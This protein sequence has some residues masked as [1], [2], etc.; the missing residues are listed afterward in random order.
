MAGENRSVREVE[1]LCPQL[2]EGLRFS[3]DEIGGR[4]VC[5]IEDTLASR[6]HRVGLAE[7]RFFRA[8]DGT[9]TVA[10]ILAQLARDGGGESF[11]EH[12]ALQMIRWLKDNH[13]LAVESVRDET[14]RREHAERLM[15]FAATWLNPL[16][17]K[18]PLARPDA[19]FARVEPA[20]RWAL[21]GFG[22]AVWLV[23][24]ITGAV[25]AGMD[26]P[27]FTS[28]FDGILSR[29]NWLWLFLVWAGLKVAHEFSHGIFCKHFGAAVRELGVIFVIFIPMGY[30]DATASVGLAS[31]WRRIMV[32]LAG[33]Y[34]EFFLAA[35]AAIVWARTGS[36]LLNTVAHN[37]VVTGTV[38][39]LLFNANPLMRFDGY[40][41]LS[42]LLDLPN[43]ATRG[44]AWFQRAFAWLVIGGRALRPTAP[45]NREDGTIAL[46]GTASAVWQVVVL[47]GLLAGAS[48]TFRGGGVLLAAIGCVAWIGVP[49]MNFI[50]TFGRSGGGRLWRTGL[51]VMA[52]CAAIA[53]G[54]F[55]PF[56]RSVSSPGVI[57][58][59]DTQVLRAECPGF[60]EKV[61]VRDG[62]TVRRGQLLM[63]L[64]NEEAAAQLAKSR[65]DLDQQE[66]RARVAFNK[67]DV[68]SY[69][70]ERA[71]A[72]ALRTTVS[73]HESYLA[74]MQIRA[75]IDGRVT[76]RRLGNMQGEFIQ[77]GGEL[78]QIGR[79]DGSDVRIAV[80]QADES[81]LRA[82]VNQAV[83]VRIAGRDEVCDGTLLRIEA[84]A[85]REIIHPALTALAGGPLA[86]RQNEE[87]IR[88]DGQNRKPAYELAE[89]QF[90]AMAHLATD[91]PLC[92]GEMARVKFRSARTVTLWGELEGVLARWMKKYSDREARA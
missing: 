66:L 33:V 41:V 90:C 4:R 79:D 69:Q 65:V 24:V 13:L 75:P 18:L 25:H 77:S 43:L 70:A 88:D 64:A 15:R 82:A 14:G 16:V 47:I 49:A 27:R 28:G 58:L 6:F 67:G 12:E 50:A 73:N 57:E 8:L 80:T 17:V 89:P 30:V 51:R 5:V 83:R 48:V 45:R 53:A 7:Y 85:T 86:L 3:V 92:V 40:Y 71:K 36:G 72:D 55:I 9:R 10:S 68:S 91:T 44:R 37:A 39:T 1:S 78:L 61:H 56:H 60:V 19:F 54:L 11:N 20:L 38:V 35:I 23:V 81:H 29:E 34:M 2:R 46:Y 32:S 31:K 42:D 22:F 84:R 87:A 59:A 76:N 62:E 26:W 21:G 63:E 74:T 52:I